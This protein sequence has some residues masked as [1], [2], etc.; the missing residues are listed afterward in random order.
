MS[1]SQESRR[2]TSS[3]AAA[4][5]P[6][7]ASAS[8]AS[9]TNATQPPKAQPQS[10]PSPPPGSGA[11]RKGPPPNAVLVKTFTSLMS[12]PSSGS[13]N[14]SAGSHV[15]PP[16]LMPA[17]AA[18][19]PTQCWYTSPFTL[20]TNTPMS[21]FHRTWRGKVFFSPRAVPVAASELLSLPGEK[22][23]QLRVCEIGK[24]LIYGVGYLYNTPLSVEHQWRGRV[25]HL[26]RVR[27]H[28]APIPR[29]V[30]R[31]AEA[32]ASLQKERRDK[33]KDKLNDNMQ[34]PAVL[35]P[36]GSSPPS[37]APQGKA[38]VV[39]V[40]YTHTMCFERGEASVYECPGDDLLVGLKLYVND[41]LVEDHYPIVNALPQCTATLAVKE[42]A[43]HWNCVPFVLMG[44]LN[45]QMLDPICIYH[46]L[47]LNFVEHLLRVK[48]P[49]KATLASPAKPAAPGS[50]GTKTPPTKKSS[51]ASVDLTLRVEVVYGCRAE[52]YYCTDFI[53]RG[54][55]VLRMTE[56]SKRALKSYE[57]KLR[58][59]VR[60]RRAAP[61]L[62]PRDTTLSNSNNG[63]GRS[64]SNNNDNSSGSPPPPRNCSVC[65]HPLQY[66]CTVCGADVCGMPTCVANTVVGYPRACT[67]HTVAPN[68]Q[69]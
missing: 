13:R 52:A 28:Q 24:D 16:S 33:A 36:P 48:M 19:V 3:D 43:R 15:Q 34:K 68:Q 17:A 5:S 46:T 65:G 45:Q 1:K 58:A 8:S 60:L 4:A 54:S 22:P 2:P 26:L 44:Y 67:R 66:R 38:Q 42:A 6:A 41:V 59:L 32:L 55:C 62:I 25:V 49:N 23:P 29:V 50:G 7:A 18:C 11:G 51:A 12:N 64:D 20:S 57:E 14:G 10:Q 47:S 40:D 35:A 30:L 69:N 37:P 63:S 56:S 9:S 21:E 53:S 61:K 27:T 39:S 31:R